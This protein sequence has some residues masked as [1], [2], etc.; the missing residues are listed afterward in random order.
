MQL[1]TN[2]NNNKNPITDT[3]FGMEVKETA[4]LA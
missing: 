4:F 3:V 2:Y 1:P